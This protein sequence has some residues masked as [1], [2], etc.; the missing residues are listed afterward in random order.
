MKA[1]T[2]QRSIKL[3][4]LDTELKNEFTKLYLSKVPCKK[5]QE[6]L[7]LTLSQVQKIKTHLGLK[8]ERGYTEDDLYAGK[9]GILRYKATNEKIKTNHDK[10]GYLRCTL[11][12]KNVQVHR[13][14]AK[15]YIPN[16]ENK[17][18]VNHKN[19][20]KDDNRIENLE[21]VTY[22]E[23]EQHS[24]DVLGKKGQRVPSYGITNG[25][26]KPFVDKETNILY[27]SRE[28]FI[29]SNNVSKSYLYKLLKTCPKRFKN[30]PRS[31]IWLE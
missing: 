21:W 2:E 12:Y 16:P 27:L 25:S 13:V 11:K 31:K 26:A 17:P 19:G 23:N 1:A 29:N 6:K 18:C 28:D 8:R 9:D 7:N 5:I 14:V 3:N 22:S 20:I 24:Y 4:D 15:K 10:D 30:I